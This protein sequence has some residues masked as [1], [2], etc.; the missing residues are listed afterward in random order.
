MAFHQLD[1]LTFLI[2]DDDP[3]ELRLL[4]KL[5][6]MLG[7][8][9]VKRAIDG[10]EAL[11]I[12]RLVPVHM[13]ICD[14][15]MTPM[16]GLTFVRELRRLKLGERSLVPVIMTTGH[17]ETKSVTAARDDGATEVLAKP[18]TPM[19]LYRRIVA[20]LATPRPFISEAGFKGPDRRR[21]RQP[22]AKLERRRAWQ[23]VT[24]ESPG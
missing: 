10:S 5:V 15:R 8:R 14:L 18:F 17:T 20:T 23:S 22:K 13:I 19:E 3:D 11:E 6:T 1:R 12:L 4:E 2:V 7:V 24:E 21:Q 16:D 9:R